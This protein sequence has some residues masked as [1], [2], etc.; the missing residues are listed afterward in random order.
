[1]VLNFLPT[2]FI[3]IICLIIYG[4]I[5]GAQLFYIVT[6]DTKGS[7]IR[8]LR[9]K[10]WNF[11]PSL[12]FRQIY[13]SALLKIV[14]V[15]HKYSLRQSLLCYQSSIPLLKSALTYLKFSS[16]KDETIT[17]NDIKFEHENW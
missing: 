2:F 12:L 10:I 11:G 4:L 1:M 8:V 15:L 14:D 16:P 6:F 13:G 9:G 17:A 3:D 7:V 5:K